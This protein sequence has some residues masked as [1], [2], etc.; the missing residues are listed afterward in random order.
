MLQIQIINQVY[1]FKKIMEWENFQSALL[2]G[3]WNEEVYVSKSALRENEHFCLVVATKRVARACFP[4]QKIKSLGF[5]D[6]KNNVPQVAWM[7]RNHIHC[8]KKHT[9]GLFLPQS[10]SHF[11]PLNS[12]TRPNGTTS[13]KTH[14]SIIATPST[15]STTTNSTRLHPEPRNT[16]S[17]WDP[18][19]S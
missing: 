16:N 5:R 8:S 10:T 18:L 13:I 17:L 1:R 3:I 2:S 15:A 9:D 12:H 6:C 14:K 4:P 7:L 19:A 11:P